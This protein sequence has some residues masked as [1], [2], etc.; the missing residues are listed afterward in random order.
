MKYLNL[1]D[2]RVVEGPR[3]YSVL[4]YRHKAFSREFPDSVFVIETSLGCFDSR[5][6]AF[7]LAQHDKV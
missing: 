1:A 3:Q 5:L 2:G 7:A 4:K 6:L